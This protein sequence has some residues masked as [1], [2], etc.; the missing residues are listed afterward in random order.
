MQ[1]QD[2]LAVQLGPIT[3]HEEDIFGIKPLAIRPYEYPDIVHFA[4]TFEFDLNLYRIDRDAYNT[5]S[6]LGDVGGLKEALVLIGAGLL[7]VL[8]YQHYDNFMVSK[9]FRKAKEKDKKGTGKAEGEEMNL[10]AI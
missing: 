9:L 7:S 6:W 8:Q 2:T 10:S 3:E 5:L 4:I 1:L